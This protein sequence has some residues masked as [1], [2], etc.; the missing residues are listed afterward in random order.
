MTG[1]RALLTVLAAA[2]ALSACTTSN[3][4]I[5]DKLRRDTANPRILMMPP[6]VEL[7]EVTAAGLNEVNA[8]WTVAGRTNLDRAVRDHLSAINAQYAAFAPPAEDSGEF[9]RFD[10]V[11]K[12]HG[13]VGT[14]IYVHHLIPAAKPLPGKQ[15]KFDWALGPAAVELGAQSDADY[16]LFLHVRDS[17][18]S[19]GRAAMQF[20]AAALF[21]VALPGGVQ[22]GYASLVD[23]KT[24]EIVWFN[25]LR[26]ESG[27]LRTPGPAKETVASLLDKLPK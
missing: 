21:G 3:V 14:Y 18:T 1:I 2:L 6:D 17:Y 26:R 12:L 15:G 5:T 24:G 10:Q 8:Q 9:E 20:M 11:Q 16:A 19:A 22:V 7:S 13:V 23:L 25:A 27:D 4:A